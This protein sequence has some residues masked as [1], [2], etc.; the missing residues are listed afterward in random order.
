MSNY[1]LLFAIFLCIA[2]MML[3]GK[4]ENKELERWTGSFE[5][6]DKEKNYKLNIEQKNEKEV[7]LSLDAGE[8]GRLDNVVALLVDEDVAVYDGNGVTVI[9]KMEDGDLKVT[10][11]EGEPYDQFDRLVG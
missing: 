1:T 7:A 2:T 6:H 10:K 8:K 3:C 4:K 11:G 9:M 5:S